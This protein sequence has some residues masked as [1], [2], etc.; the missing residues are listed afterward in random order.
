MIREAFGSVDPLEAQ[1]HMTV[2]QYV[3]IVSPLK[4]KFIHH[5]ETKKLLRELVADCGCNLSETYVDVPRLR[6]VTSHG[7]LTAGVG[8]AHHLH[9]DTWYSGP[10][11]QLN[12]WL[13]IYGIESESSMAFHPAYWSKAVKNGSSEFNYYNWNSEGRKNAAQHIKTDTRKQPKAEEPMEL[14]PQIRLIVPPGGVILFSGAQ[15]HST[16]PN[17]SGRA[18]YSIDFRTVNLA[19]LRAGSAAPNVDSYPVG[20]SLR[21][22]VRGSDGA[23]M[24]DEIVQKYDNASA[25]DGVLVYRPGAE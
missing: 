13:P 10:M 17:T 15:M 2:E 1:F 23:P 25:D 19:D 20:T 7:Y 8:Y 9:R 4:P 12:W 5:P 11:A 3:A 18:R 16:V 21:D 22:F 6:M 24:P 14:D